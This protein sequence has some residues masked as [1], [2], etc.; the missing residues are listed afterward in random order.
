MTDGAV[1]R[2]LESDWRALCDGLAKT[3]STVHPQH[4]FPARPLG[5]FAELEEV[6]SLVRALDHRLL[7]RYARRYVNSLWTL[8]DLLAHLASWAGEFRRQAETL[9]TGR[10]PEYAIPFALSIIGPNEWN[11]VEVERRQNRTLVDVLAE[12]ESE[13]QFLQD[14]VLSLTKDELSRPALLPAA[15]SG[16]PAAR[17]RGTIAFVISG[18]CAHD[19]YHFAG[20]RAWVEAQE[21]LRKR[22][23]R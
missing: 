6:L 2:L 11:Q 19:R 4:P 18:K 1:L 12:F 23:P 3:T 5:L 10:E 16:D 20:L 15:P 9:A 7:R 14:L 22:R 21:A 8:Q 13:T 17:I